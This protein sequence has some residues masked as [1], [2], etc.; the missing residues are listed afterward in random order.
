MAAADRWLTGDGKR[1]LWNYN[2]TWKR[3]GKGETF[4]AQARARQDQRSSPPLLERFS[5]AFRWRTGRRALVDYTAL[6]ALALASV[7]GLL[8]HSCGLWRCFKLK[9]SAKN[10][11]KK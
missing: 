2:F 6:S 11:R 7:E 10:Q 8:G 1:G 9:G 4:P 3:S 5:R